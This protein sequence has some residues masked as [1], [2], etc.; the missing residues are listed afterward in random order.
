MKWA[1]LPVWDG[2]LGLDPCG[3]GSVHICTPI[4]L[5]PGACMQSPF[6]GSVKCSWGRALGTSCSG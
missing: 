4:L 5:S 2:F 1:E 6:H 3:K